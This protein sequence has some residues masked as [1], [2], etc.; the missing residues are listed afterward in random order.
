MRKRIMRTA[1]KKGSAV[2]LVEDSAK[3]LAPDQVRLRVAACGI[4]GTDLH[5]NPGEEERE[6]G[7]GHEIAGTVIETGSAVRNVRIGQAAVLES[8]TPCGRCE[9]CR[10]ARQDLC[11]DIQSFFYLGSFGF[12]DK[13]IAPGIS[14]IV[15]DDL[16]PAVACL[17]EPLGVAIDM[18]RLADIRLDSNLRRQPLLLTVADTEGSYAIP[19]IQTSRDLA[20]PIDFDLPEQT[21]ASVR[22]LRGGAVVGEQTVL[23][24]DPVARFSDLARAEYAAE[25]TACDRAGKALAVTI[26]EP[27]GVGTVLAALGDSITEG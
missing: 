24:I 14:A 9:N 16:D 27:I 7:F 19:H 12:A 15:C 18:V 26:I 20:I 5:E 17:S 8:A 10:N 22:L 4:C 13:M 6:S 3:P 11:T 25:V 23:P 1:L 21:E 2:R